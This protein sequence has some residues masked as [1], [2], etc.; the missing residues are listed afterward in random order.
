MAD[1]KPAKKL[2]IPGP[3]EVY[4]EIREE[5]ARP[6]IGH[7]SESFRALYRE[8]I[9]G[10][11]WLLGETRAHVFTST[12]SATGVWEGAARNC[13]RKG[14]LHL[15]NGA[16]SERWEEVTRLNARPTGV[17]AV[18]WGKAHRAD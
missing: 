6:M 2:F 4:P 10:L 9:P 1:R 14:T 18:E 11:R 8:V 7:R 13:V 16:F 12:S 15:V 17:Y 5:M 3:V